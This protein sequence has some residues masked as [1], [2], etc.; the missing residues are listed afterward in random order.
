M[1]ELVAF[2]YRWRDLPFFRWFLLRLGL[3]PCFHCVLEILSLLAK[4]KPYDQ[5]GAVARVLVR[6]SNIVLKYGY[7]PSQSFLERRNQIDVLY[8][9]L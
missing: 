2:L 9:L 4:R 6:R 7:D 5:S 3:L 8:Y 1:D